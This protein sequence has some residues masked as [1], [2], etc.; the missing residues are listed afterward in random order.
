MIITGEAFFGIPR[1]LYGSRSEAVGF[2]IQSKRYLKAIL[3]DGAND[4]GLPGVPTWM[5]CRYHHDTMLF[6]ED[7][8]AIDGGSSP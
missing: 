7:R 1:K 4:V 2:W 6:D 5:N 3:F 8:E